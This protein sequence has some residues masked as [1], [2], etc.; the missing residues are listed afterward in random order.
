MFEVLVLQLYDA[1][2]EP[3]AV[4]AG[5]SS[6]ASYSLVLLIFGALFAAVAAV[7]VVAVVAVFTALAPL[8]WL[9]MAA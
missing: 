7:A 8:L 2:P 1:T 9:T 3:S 5:R 6:S 4:T